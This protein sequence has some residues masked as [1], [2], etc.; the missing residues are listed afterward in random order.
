M[1]RCRLVI[2]RTLSSALF[3]LGVAC[4]SDGGEATSSATAPPP[5]T[6]SVDDA[7]PRA[8]SASAS[9]VVSASA[10]PSASAVS[11]AASPSA[12]AVVRPPP[13]PPRFTKDHPTCPIPDGFDAWSW[14]RL[15]R[16]TGLSERALV[17]T[18][19]VGA[20]IDNLEKVL[21]LL[22]EREVKTTI[23][24]Y[25]GELESHP[26]GR[27]VIRRMADD[28]HE[29][30]NHT[31]SH[32]DLTKLEEAAVDEQFDRVEALVKDAT[33]RSTK[34]FFREPFLATNEAID[35]KIK[36][37]CYRPIWFTIDTADWNEGATAAQIEA[38]VFEKRGKPR[39]IETGSIFIFHGSVKANLVALPRI[40]ER[41]RADGWSFLTLGEALRR[42]GGV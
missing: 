7:S 14:K 1:S 10:A 33:G 17:L 38:A 9:A 22:K 18:L 30:A 35:R 23:F 2:A 34:P 12:S 24:L 20:R 29:L 25:T 40:I 27:A 19:D 39:E 4:G 3:A 13:G 16:V 5:P 11:S 15:H 28:G 36:D 37:K 42:S 26:R 21:D 32:K 41:L 31:L 8:S 6:S